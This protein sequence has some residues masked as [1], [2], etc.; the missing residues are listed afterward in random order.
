MPI[1][2]IAIAPPADGGEL[3]DT[4]APIN[5]TLRL[6]L[7]KQAVGNGTCRMVADSGTALPNIPGEANSAILMLEAAPDADLTATLARIWLDGTTPTEFKGLAVTHGAAFE[8]TCR[9]DLVRARLFP[10]DGL[11][12][13][14]NVQYFSV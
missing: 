8:I 7:E 9:R 5:N 14:L 1:D 6:G 10:C 4:P 2:D 12:H 3:I 13:L 11:N